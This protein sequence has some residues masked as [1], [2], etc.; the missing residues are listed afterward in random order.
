VPAERERRRQ[1]RHINNSHRGG[2]DRSGSS[3]IR[4]VSGPRATW[5]SSTAV[6]A[7]AACT[8]IKSTGSSGM[9]RRPPLYYA[10]TDSEKLAVV[11]C[12][13]TGRDSRIIS[14]DVRPLVAVIGRLAINIGDRKRPR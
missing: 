6:V 1:M 11:T 12:S 2:D 13:G 10:T 14:D 5:A 9:D 4:P 3:R 8:R 7:A